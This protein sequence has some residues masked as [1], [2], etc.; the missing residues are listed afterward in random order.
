MHIPAREYI[1][2]IFN[3]LCNIPY[4]EYYLDLSPPL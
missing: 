3:Y 4:R 1:N 2:I